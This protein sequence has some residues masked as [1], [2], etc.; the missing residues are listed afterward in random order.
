MAAD[1]EHVIEACKKHKAKLVVSI[2]FIVTA[3][4]WVDDGRNTDPSLQQKG[5]VRAAIANKILDE[6]KQG[7]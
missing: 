6:V 1:H 5:E 7:T 2:T 3:G 4:S